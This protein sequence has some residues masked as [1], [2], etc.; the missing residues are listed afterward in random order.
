MNS[1]FVQLIGNK[2][3]WIWLGLLCTKLVAQTP[4]E[5]LV[6]QFMADKEYAKALPMAE[7]LYKSNGSKELYYEWL[8]QC[9]MELG[10]F[11]NALQLV[12]K[13]AKKNKNDLRY[14]VD[15][16]WI[17][18]A[19]NPGNDAYER[20]IEKLTVDETV[21]REALAA[22]EKR[23]MSK[24]ALKLLERADFVLEKNVFFEK[25][26]TEYYMREGNKRQ[27]LERF[28]LSFNN[29]F[30]GGNDYVKYFVDLNV[31]DSLDYVLFRDV[32]IGELQKNPQN[33]IMNTYVN[34]CFVQL[35]DWN[36]AYVFN[37][38]L[39]KRLGMQGAKMMELAAVC[40]ENREYETAYKCYNY[41][42]DNST[43][44]RQKSAAELGLIRCQFEKM[45]RSLDTTGV[46]ML[47]KQ[48]EW[49]Y[50][51]EEN[52][53]NIELALLLSNLYTKQA[54]NPELAD[55][56][57]QQYAELPSLDMLKLARAKMA[58]AEVL[59]LLDD[60]WTSELLYAQVEKD[61]GENPLGQEA[62]FKRAQLSYYRGDFEWSNV[63]LNVLKEATTQTIANNAIELSL[64]ITENLGLDSN[65]DALEKFAKAQLF[66]EQGMYDYAG[67][68]LDSINLLY[69]GSTLADNILFQK[70]LIASKE[71]RYTDAAESYELLA[72][73]FSHDVLADDALFNL[74]LLY[75]HVLKLPEKAQAFFEKIVVDM[76][77]SLYAIE[78][79]KYVRQLRGDKA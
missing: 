49:A 55:A 79:R 34:W 74:G 30:F 14:E 61:F 65:Y 15:E 76:P 59:T 69:P 13:A 51:K 35:A 40:M 23:S 60:M 45:Q 71:G 5:K 58:W 10:G 46:Y 19:A 70:A 11:N 29:P 8:L 32:L 67:Q 21:F 36:M 31:R 42:K 68:L 41:A 26:L 12:K 20:W 4:D 38:G 57:W 27:A 75:M 43:A 28:V 47:L 9:H 22:L 25:K 78:A 17:N 6:A 48:V 16:L 53:D 2:W 3:I 52:E 72:K 18:N 64:L 77:G 63:Q 7:N 1:I 62:K 50:Q 56:M 54:K 24:A 44:E 39:D 37:K 33:E 73:A 66:T